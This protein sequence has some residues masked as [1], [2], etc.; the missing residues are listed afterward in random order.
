MNQT[1]KKIHVDP[2]IPMA[3]QIA[4]L[5]QIYLNFQFNVFEVL[6][7]KLGSDGIEIFEAI[8]RR[9]T[10]QG[11]DKIKDKKFEEIRKMAGISDRILGL[12]VRQDYANP[13]ELQYSITYCPFLEESKQRGLDMDFC[14]II[15]KVQMEEVSKN[16]AELTEPAR[17]C[18][19]DSKCTIRMRNTLRR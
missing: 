12:S 11:I 17:M 15:E 2:D 16:L 19:G 13:D 18:Q 4:F 5:R 14:N 7:E 1:E 10:R 6:K 9:C 8:L 3:K